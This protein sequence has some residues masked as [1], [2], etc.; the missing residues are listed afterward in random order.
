MLS[1][2]EVKAIFDAAGNL[3]HHCLLMLVYS[4][5]LRVGGAAGVLPAVCSAAVRI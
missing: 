3:K 2:S 1:L 5:G 4:A